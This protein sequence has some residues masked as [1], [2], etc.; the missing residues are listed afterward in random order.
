MHCSMLR[1]RRPWLLPRWRLRSLCA[2]SMPVALLVL[3]YCPCPIVYIEAGKET[4]FLPAVYKDASRSSAHRLA[5]RETTFL[6]AAYKDASRFSA[7]RLYFDCFFRRRMRLITNLKKTALRKPW[8][9]C[10]WGET[11]VGWPKFIH[12]PG[13]VCVYIFTTNQMFSKIKLDLEQY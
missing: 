1:R 4:T 13:S 9:T 2:T 6:A 7:R 5:G 3:F 10:P 8:P 12:P 11:R